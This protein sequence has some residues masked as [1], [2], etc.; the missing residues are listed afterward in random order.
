MLFIVRLRRYPRKF[1]AK[2]MSLRVTGFEPELGDADS[3]RVNVRQTREQLGER[4]EALRGRIAKA[5]RDQRRRG[6]ELA[7]L[8]Y[9]LTQ[10]RALF[11][12]EPP[13]A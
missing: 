6:E 4:I 5:E 8:R 9:E 10:L 12:N 2:G 11:R 1:S 13:T 7:E 3:E